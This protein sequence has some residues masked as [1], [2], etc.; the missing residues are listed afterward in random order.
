[1]DRR[2][3]SLAA[4]LVGIL[5]FPWASTPRRALASDPLDKPVATEAKV[6]SRQIVGRVVDPEGQGIPDADVGL[7]VVEDINNQSQETNPSPPSPK[8]MPVARSASLGE[9]NS[10][11]P[12]E[13]FGR[14][15]RIRAPAIAEHGIDRGVSS[16][17]PLASSTSCNSSPGKNTTLLTAGRAG[18]TGR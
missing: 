5:V 8:P 10:K 4:L 16:V 1:M 3:I 14:M 7:M 18:E 11:R 6:S 2:A 17:T 13:R 12:G 15:P 9:T